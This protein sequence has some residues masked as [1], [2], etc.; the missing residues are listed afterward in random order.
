VVSA[1]T[2]FGT[3]P[4]VRKEAAPSVI[5]FRRC[6]DRK[7]DRQLASPASR[8]GLISIETCSQSRQ[9][10]TARVMNIVTTGIDFQ[11]H[12]SYV[13]VKA[14][15]WNVTMTVSPLPFDTN[16]FLSV[17]PLACIASPILPL[18]PMSREELHMRGASA[19]GAIADHLG[20]AGLDMLRCRR[21][22]G[23]GEDPASSGSAVGDG[24][25]TPQNENKTP[26]NVRGS[27]STPDAKLADPAAETAIELSPQ[28]AC[29]SREESE[30]QQIQRA[31][32][33]DSVVTLEVVNDENENKTPCNLSEA[34]HEPAPMAGSP[35]IEVANGLPVMPAAT[36][37][38]AL[39]GGPDRATEATSEFHPGNAGGDATPPVMMATGGVPDRRH[40]C[41]PI[42]APASASVT[43]GKPGSESEPGAAITGAVPNMS[44]KETN[45]I[46]AS[47]PLGNESISGVGP[48]P[49][50]GRRR[51]H[52]ARR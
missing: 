36:A 52:W 6:A 38:T 8:R 18:H 16:D 20:K 30:S 35:T 17:L 7:P 14:V 48:A 3:L 41:R 27:A 1:D 34:L 49:I 44:K 24:D 11:L 37:T 22:A 29:A 9:R 31:A 39:A 47:P 25:G 2:D 46:L 51:G 19:R 28:H 33:I 40:D 45:A 13:T 5:V 21:R 12:V 23:I 43:A 4:A 50:R 32:G 26:C 10:A 15:P 42:R